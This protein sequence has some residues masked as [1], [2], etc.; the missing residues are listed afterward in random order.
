VQRIH[1]LRCI[2]VRADLDHLAIMP[3]CEPDIDDVEL[4]AC[5]G[6]ASQQC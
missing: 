4:V 5:S 2:Y 1:D 3:T 6:S